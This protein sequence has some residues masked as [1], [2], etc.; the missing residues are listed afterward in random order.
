MNAVVV[1]TNVLIVANGASQQARPEHIIACI[2]ALEKS[3]LKSI[4]SIDSENRILDEYF[5]GL[6]PIADC[7]LL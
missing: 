2:D 5:R 7:P 3:S 4:I 1:D 6:P